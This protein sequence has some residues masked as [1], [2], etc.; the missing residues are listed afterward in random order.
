MF[1]SNTGYALMHILTSKPNTNT[2]MPNRPN[3]QRQARAQAPAQPQ[4]AN[5]AG[6]R[7]LTPQQRQQRQQRQ[8]QRQQQGGQPQA[9]RSTARP[10][11]A[12]G[13]WRWLRVAVPYLLALVVIIIGGVVLY[14]NVNDGSQ[15]LKKAQERV[16]Q[17]ENQAQADA[18]AKAE[19]EADLAQART[20]ADA[21]LA[22]KAKAEEIESVRL[23]RLE[24][25]RKANE[26]LV[27]QK[28]EAE[29]KLIRLETEAKTRTEEVASSSKALE[30]EEQDGDWIVTSIEEVAKDPIL[31]VRMWICKGPTGKPIVATPQTPGD[32]VERYVKFNVKRPEGTVFKAHPKPS[33]RGSTVWVLVKE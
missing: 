16:A 26:E 3:N 13:K 24:G 18:R 5:P 27:R 14:H 23:E 12:G 21:A 32:Y 28:A 29:A 4:P 31:G 33:R 7:Q 2:T 8:R 6:A 9:Q 20:E 10:A 11:N 17:A 15:A 1:F 22:A 30:V 19:A 25:L